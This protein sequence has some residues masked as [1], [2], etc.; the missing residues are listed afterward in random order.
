MLISVVDKNRYG[1]FE[2]SLALTNFFLMSGNEN[3]AANL[4]RSDGQV[5]GALNFSIFKLLSIIYKNRAATLVVWSVGISY[6]ILPIINLFFSS[7]KIIVVIHEPGGIVQR[8]KKGDPLLYAL[9]VSFYELLLFFS[10]VIKVTPN[11][12]NSKKYNL[13]YAPLLFDSLNMNQTIM[14]KSTVVYLGRK[15]EVRSL[16]LF[17]FLKDNKALTNF[18]FEFFPTLK[19]STEDKKELMEKAVCTLNLYVV[20][21]NQSGVTVDSLRFAIPVVVTNFDAFGDLILHRNAGVVIPIDSLSM[22]SV[23]D[24][25]NHIKSNFVAMSKSAYE[26]YEDEFGYTAFC[27]FWLPIL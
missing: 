1:L 14:D 17:K 12:K 24:A 3:K 26:L 19:T 15:A 11:V 22:S 27:S 7:V 18:D 23:L 13:I 4:F 10:K 6:F 20:P 25:I 16:S 9:A 8:L 21:H 5:H 2:H